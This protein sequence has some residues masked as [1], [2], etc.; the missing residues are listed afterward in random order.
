[1]SA[2]TRGALLLENGRF[3]PASAIGA[4]SSLCA[5]GATQPTYA[6]GHESHDSAFR[7]CRSGDRRYS[8]S[9]PA[10]LLRLPVRDASDALHVVV[11]T[12]GGSRVKLKYSPKLGTFVLS[13]PLALGVSYPFDWGFVPSTRGADGDPVDAMIL[14]DTATYPGVVVCCRPLGVLEVEQNAKGGGRERNDRIVVEP[15]S[16]HRPTTPLTDR[17]RK[18][19]EAFFVATTWFEGKDLRLLGWGEAA[20]AE[21]LIRHATNTS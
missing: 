1:M 18:E 9:M 15:V 6:A 11:E 2:S 13:R 17:V 14:S 5:F 10:D 8:R 4:E 21:A 16:V 19:L 20:A 7:D 12:P 3:A